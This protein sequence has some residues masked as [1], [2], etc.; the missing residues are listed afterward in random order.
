[1]EDFEYSTEQ[2]SATEEYL[3][4]YRRPTVSEIRKMSGT[5]APIKLVGGTT[6]PKH[7]C[8][9]CGK[10]IWIEPPLI[11]GGCRDATSPEEKDRLGVDETKFLS[12]QTNGCPNQGL[13]QMAM[14]T[15]EHI[16]LKN[17]KR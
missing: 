4:Q 11:K 9:L 6:V 7:H 12:Q 14:H 8:T 5:P 15:A 3:Q 17:Q 16:Y 1:M 2:T 10:Q 13:Y